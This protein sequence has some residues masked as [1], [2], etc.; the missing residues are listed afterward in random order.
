[1]NLDIEQLP[2]RCDVLVVGAGPAGS[3][4][5]RMLARGGRSVVLVDARAFPRDKVC[6]DGLAPDAHRALDRLGMLEAV[7][8][9]AR[10]SPGLGVVAPRGG[11]IDVPGNLAVL[12]R[13]RFD[14]I[15]CRG[16]V[17]A[18]ALMFAPLRFVAPL[19]A[20][21]AAGAV[22]GACLQQGG[23]VRRIDATWLLLA[24]GAQPQALIAT[25]MCER[26]V[27]SG[28]ALRGYIRNRAMAS[29]I[30]SMEVVWH[31]RFAPGYGWIF[32]CGDDVFNIGVGVICGEERPQRGSARA[33]PDLNLRDAFS[34]FK[35]LYAPAA[36]LLAGG[37]WQAEP[38][39]ELTGAPL[40][41]SLAGARFEAP[42]VLVIGEAAG[43][44]Y[45]VTGEGIGKAME[46]AIH[47]AE[48]I[49]VGAAGDAGVEADAAV[50][51]DYAARLLALQ[52]RFALYEQAQRATARP[53]LIDLLVWSARRSPRRMDR[54][55]G[56]L[57][58]THLPTDAATLRGVLRRL[59]D[60]R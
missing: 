48:A 10:P 60:L 47:A 49:L 3:A 34:A 7:L 28:I 11:R 20:D 37:T 52:P 59:F 12:A 14:A 40:R 21:G 44:T 18:G 13:K 15:L 41:C 33:K 24:S 45:A 25:G 46:T 58:E 39:R 29:R 19:R 27:P 53:W 54:I 42:G 56:L 38:G 55:A 35:D 8:A 5:A 6:G 2:S 51:A 26:R 23:A 50:R 9:E 31:K 1:M 16:A 22:V 17:E 57:E 43:A 32:P 4:A 36:E 30:T